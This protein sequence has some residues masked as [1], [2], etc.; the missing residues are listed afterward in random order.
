MKK[1]IKEEEKL[2]LLVERYR[3]VT[4]Y[5]KEILFEDR[6]KIFHKRESYLE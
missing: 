6:K 2:N 1:E 3:I 4:R 5:A